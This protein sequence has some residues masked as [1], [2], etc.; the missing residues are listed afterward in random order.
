VGY[1]ED[2][3]VDI[4][5]LHIE[6]AG[7]SSL[8][9]DYAEQFADAVAI[10]MRAQ[11]KV[12]VVKTE[13]KR[14]I[15]EKR[16]A[17]DTE[18]RITMVTEEGKKPTETALANAVI[19]CNSFIQVQNDV[20]KEIHEVTEAYIEAVRNKELLEG[21]KT[22]FSHRKAALENEV[23]LWQN[24]YY[25]DPKIPKSYKEEQQEQAKKAIEQTLKDDRPLRRRC[26]VQ[27]IEGD[28]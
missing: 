28:V 23:Q 14:K 8:Y 5:N 10:M 3:K 6:W 9:L 19:T 15:D 4:Y 21:V 22:A 26:P 1:K 20:A 24:G 17:L 16:A 13:G 2:A 27:K 11:E 25:S 18:F 12:N 7:Q